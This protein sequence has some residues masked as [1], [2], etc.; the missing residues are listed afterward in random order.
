MSRGRTGRG[1]EQV[2]ID[3]APG[4]DGVEVAL[5]FNR[6]HLLIGRVPLKQPEQAAYTFLKF[7]NYGTEGFSNILKHG[8]QF[9]L[10][11][12]RRDREERLASRRE[13]AGKTIMG[14][15]QELAQCIFELPSLKPIIKHES[16]EEV[17]ARAY[18]KG[19]S[20]MWGCVGAVRRSVQ[21]VKMSM[22]K[23]NSFL[24]NPNS[25]RVLEWA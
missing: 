9:G 15:F 10:H 25:S 11:I 7:E 19:V 4:K 2:G 1:Y 20:Y 12:V 14:R 17:V 6:H 21:V 22:V 18:G 3:F 24:I 16:L 23:L 5:P 8:V 13:T